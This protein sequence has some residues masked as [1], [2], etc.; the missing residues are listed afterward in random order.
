[1]AT[2]PLLEKLL[3]RPAA[4]A[5][6]GRRYDPDK[7]FAS[8]LEVTGDIAEVEIRDTKGEV[9]EGRARDFLEGEGLDPNQYIVASF[10]KSQ[11]GDASS[12][13]ESVAF[14]FKRIG[15]A[16]LPIELPD[17]DDLH[18]AVKRAVADRKETPR[19]RGPVAP[20]RSVLTTLA[21]FQ[22][23]K[24]GERGGTEELLRRSEEAKARWV[25]YV[26]AENPY[27]IILVDLG[28]AIENFENAGAQERTNDLQLTEQLR[29]WRRIF[30]SWIDEASRLAPSVKVIS[31]PSNHCQVRRGKNV[32]GTPSDD[33][34]IEVLSQV[35]DM[36]GVNS[37]LYGHVEFFAPPNQEESLAIEAVG[38]KILGFAH[39][40]QAS[41][42]DK[43]PTWIAGQALGRT[44]IGNADIICFGHFHHL[45][46][47]TIGNDRW[48]FVAPTMD[49][50]SAW[51]RNISGSE[52]APGVLTMVIESDGWRALHVC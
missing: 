30:W 44:P 51:W 18:E 45:R 13:K 40:H 46:V 4:P 49:S 35:A 14:T 48:M 3:A 38:G 31:V 29:A 32:L 28:D 11:W 27:E 37:E 17:M 9:T 34:G 1:M 22:T 24:T 8:K 2:D 10:K 50:G 43:F 42:P 7:D 39:G 52:S 6:T 5:A 15:A 21:D 16:T 12:P 19:D 33:Y 41:N 36:A 23:G 26:K 25:E 20:K 47:Q